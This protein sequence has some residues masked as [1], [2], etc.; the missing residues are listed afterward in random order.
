[1]SDTSLESRPLRRRRPLWLQSEVLRSAFRDTARGLSTVHLPS[2]SV[3]I[4]ETCWNVRYCHG[5]VAEAICG[6]REKGEETPA[7][8]LSPLK[9][10]TQRV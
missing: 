3:M 4:Q 7:A 9:S 10:S 1:M 2:D 8:E 6:A 5:K